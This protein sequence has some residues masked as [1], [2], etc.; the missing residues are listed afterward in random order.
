[1][2]SEFVDNTGVATTMGKVRR[3][4]ARTRK[5][6]KIKTALE[7]EVESLDKPALGGK[8]THGSKTIRCRPSLTLEIAS[9]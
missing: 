4:G 1:V 7:L 6:S 9:E 3:R 2:V 5:P 8:K